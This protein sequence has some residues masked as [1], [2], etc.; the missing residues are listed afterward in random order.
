MKDIPGKISRNIL[1]IRQMKKE[2]G[3]SWIGMIEF[4]NKW[5]LKGSFSINELWE[6][7]MDKRSNQYRK[8]ILNCSEQFK[9][10][11]ILN[12]RKYY[13]LARNKYLTHIVLD[14]AGI[15]EKSTLYGYYSPSSMDCFDKGIVG[16]KESLIKLLESKNVKS[17]VIKSTESSH[18]ENVWV[19]T[20]ITYNGLDSSIVRFDG[21]R[22]K[23]TEIMHN[24]PL[25]FESIIQQSKQFASF[26]PSSVNTIRFMTTLYPDG[27]AEVIAAFLKI[28]RAGACVD[29]AGTGGNVDAKIDIETGEI[30]YPIIFNGWRNVSDTKSHPDTNE[31]LDGVYI[32]DWEIIK[33]KVIGFQQRMPWVKAAG[34]DIAIT[35]DGPVVIEVNDFW[36]R[37]GQLFIRK[38]WKPQIKACH[39]AWKNN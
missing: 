29:N 17:C 10:L 6:L 25:I 3:M 22:I 34:W 20:D 8:E 35:E 13:I 14:Q 27:H 33:T 19:V 16:T 5:V 39:D 32:H 12:P 28:G 37:T 11:S 23:L 24:S 7:E 26:N 1:R 4:L 9:Y 30:Q 21:K 36:D 2:S 18:G 15:K 31:L 38:G